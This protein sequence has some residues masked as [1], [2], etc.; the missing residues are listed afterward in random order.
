MLRVWQVNWKRP[1]RNP[2]LNYLGRGTPKS[3]KQ[4]ILKVHKLSFDWLSFPEDTYNQ[5]GDRHL[6][7]RSIALDYMIHNYK[8]LC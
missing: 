3:H 2:I 5:L 8:G 6:I 1:F 7:K 4:L